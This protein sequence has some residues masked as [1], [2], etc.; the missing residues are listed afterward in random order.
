M[1]ELKIYQ[2]RFRQVSNVSFTYHSSHRATGSYVVQIL[3]PD[4]RFPPTTSR[5]PLCSAPWQ[6]PLFSQRYHHHH[7][8]GNQTTPVAWSAFHQPEDALR[9]I[10]EKTSRGVPEWSIAVD[11]F[12]EKSCGTQYVGMT[13]GIPDW[14][15]SSGNPEMGFVMDRHGRTCLCHHPQDPR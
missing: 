8:L 1:I 5:H 11:Q 4:T 7:K 2:K 9:G 10:P 12:S 14:R 3:V 15:P 6:V 13:R